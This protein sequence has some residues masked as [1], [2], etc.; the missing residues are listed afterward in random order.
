MS[1]KEVRN[2]FGGRQELNNTG[3]AT[4]YFEVQEKLL[5]TNR[6]FLE[7]FRLPSAAYHFDSLE[8]ET[9][10]CS[11]EH[12]LQMTLEQISFLNED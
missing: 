7:G 5:T 4:K 9:S 8:T 10:Q 3:E 12:L 2:R 6:I 1:I 11:T